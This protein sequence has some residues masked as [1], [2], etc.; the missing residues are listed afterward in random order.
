MAKIEKTLTVHTPTKE[1]SLSKENPLSWLFFVAI[2]AFVLILGAPVSLECERAETRGPV[3]CTKQTRLLWLFPLLEEKVYNVLGVH[4]TSVPGDEYCDPCYRV[5][6]ETGQGIVPLKATYTNGSS[7]MSMV[8]DKV[9]DFVHS[10]KPGNLN[11][12]E[13]GLLSL[14]NLYGFVGWILIAVI[15]SYLWE[16]AKSAFGMHKDAYS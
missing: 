3:N 1:S 8:V 2:L 5:E 12:T 6:L 10:G 7:D 13:P 15:G 14:G 16:M 4:L 11:V 9:N